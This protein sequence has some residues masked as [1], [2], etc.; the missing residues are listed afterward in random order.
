MIHSIIYIHLW[1]EDNSFQIPKFSRLFFTLG[2]LYD[3]RWY[4]RMF[5]IVVLFLFHQNISKTFNLE[6][7]LRCSSWTGGLSAWLRSYERQTSGFFFPFFFLFI[8]VVQRSLFFIVSIF[9]T[10]SLFTF[11]MSFVISINTLYVL[12]ITLYPSLTPGWS[13]T[14]NIPSNNST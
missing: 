5:I 2:Y 6:I 7:P 4:A 8:I 14:A 12:Y 13:G 3:C 9:S 11:V 10:Y 1:C